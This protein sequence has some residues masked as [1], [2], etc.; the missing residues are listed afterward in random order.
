MKTTMTS[1][2]RTTVPAAIR[3]RHGI[4][5]G[6]HVAWLDDGTTITV[7]PLPRDPV[8]ALRGTAAGEGLLEAPL[9]DRRSERDH[10]H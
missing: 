5:P 2:G 1:G 7:V 6:D 4:Q 3:R 8:R 10:D 9:A